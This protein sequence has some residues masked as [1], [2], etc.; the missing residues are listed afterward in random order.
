M[1]DDMPLETFLRWIEFDEL[2]P[3]GAAR[4]DLRMAISSAA[5][6]SM[7]MGKRGPTLKPRDFMPD[8][9]KKPKKQSA[10]DMHQKMIAFAKLF[11][12]YD[13]SH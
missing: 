9:T 8:F 5:I 11:E 1:L 13:G 6:C 7:L 12:A 3:F 4:D 10:D 2:D